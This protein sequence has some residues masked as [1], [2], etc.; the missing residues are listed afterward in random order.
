[1]KKLPKMFFLLVTICMSIATAQAAY[2][3]EIFCVE[4]KPQIL[5]VDSCIPWITVYIE[6]TGYTPEEI[7]VSTIL[8]NG[9]IAPLL[10]PSCITADV[11]CEAGVNERMVKFTRTDVAGILPLG[12][13]VEVRI[14]G[15]LN[16]ET[17]F[18]GVDVIQVIEKDTCCADYSGDGNVNLGDMVMLKR[19]F[20]R[21]NCH[22]LENPCM[23]DGNGDGKVNMGDLV[24]LKYEF[25][26]VGCPVFP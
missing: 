1:M 24:Q 17:P 14:T 20:A 18:E 4:V 12:D 9:E 15:Q 10:E 21:Q 25:G 5:N 2:A 6:P 13:E 26:K 8:L 16:D 3:Q 7:N 23:A 19:E 11:A 22:P